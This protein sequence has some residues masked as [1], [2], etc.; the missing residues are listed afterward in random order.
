MTTPPDG[1]QAGYIQNSSTF[2]QNISG[3]GS[4]QYVVSFFAEGSTTQG[5]RP[6]HVGFDNVGINP[7][8][9]VLLTFGGL[10]PITPP[11]GVFVK[12]TSDPFTLAP[13]THDLDFIG[14]TN[15]GGPVAFV[16]VVSINS[17]PEPASLTLLGIGLAG[18]AGY[19]LRRGRNKVFAVA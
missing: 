4:G 13:G 18:M 1:H 19:V 10:G 11:P 7:G 17:V 12:F 8:P 14:A 9:T 2:Y 6:I 3:F 5:T 16:D 15:G